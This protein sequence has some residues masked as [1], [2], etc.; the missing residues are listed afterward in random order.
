MKKKK[1]NRWWFTGSRFADKSCWRD[2]APRWQWW[3]EAVPKMGDDYRRFKWRDGEERAAWSYELARRATPMTLRLPTYPELTAQEQDLIKATLGK[4]DARWV[5]AFSN[6]NPERRPEGY[7]EPCPLR[8]NLAE[9]D[10]A[11]CNQFI[12]WLDSQRQKF[13]VRKPKARPNP[14]RP[15][16]WTQL[17]TFDASTLLDD[18]QR[19]A[20][21]KLRRMAVKLSEQLKT[22]LQSG[23]KYPRLRV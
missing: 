11:L 22:A 5:A 15:V 19:S 17:E 14:S 13:G 8:W 9:A 10:A 7:S 3:K 20:K 23:S 18:A 1:E 12:L 2:A 21:S 16:S 6:T 4:A